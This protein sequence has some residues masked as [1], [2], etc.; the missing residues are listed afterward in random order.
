MDIYTYNADMYCEDCVA[1]ISAPISYDG[2][3]NVISGPRPHGGGE[4]DT[5]QHCGACHVFLKNRLTTDGVQ[6]VIEALQGDGDIETLTIWFDYYRDELL[7]AGSI[8]LVIKGNSI[9]ERSDFTDNQA[10]MLSSLL[11]C[12]I[13]GQ[14][15]TP[16]VTDFLDSFC[17]LISPEDARAYLKGFGAWEDGQ[18]N[19][20]AENRQRVIWLLAGNLR[21]REPFVLEG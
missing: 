3:E 16:A 10:D 1:A 19:D 21:E 13:P 6:Y 15:A 17:V 4:A 11:D 18:L 2:G 7:D 5:P 9:I 14:E 12:A 20:H 8:E